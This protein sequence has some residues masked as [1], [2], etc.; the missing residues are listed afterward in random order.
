MQVNE[1][2]NIILEKIATADQ[3]SEYGNFKYHY[4][5]GRKAKTLVIGYEEKALVMLSTVTS[6]HALPLSHFFH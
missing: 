2:I 6:L 5:G 3:P 4:A 1:A